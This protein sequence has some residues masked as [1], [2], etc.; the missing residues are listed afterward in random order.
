MVTSK[1]VLIDPEYLAFV[2]ELEKGPEYLPSAD[3]Q[4]ELKEGNLY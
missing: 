3:K 2:A 4:L 1:Y